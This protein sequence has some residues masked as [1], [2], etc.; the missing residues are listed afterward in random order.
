M[1]ATLS[2]YN[3]PRPRRSG[4][5]LQLKGDMLGLAS[6]VHVEETLCK[7]QGLQPTSLAC[8]FWA[9]GNTMTTSKEPTQVSIASGGRIPPNNWW[10]K[11][12]LCPLDKLCYSRVSIRVTTYRLYLWRKDCRLWPET[13]K[14]LKTVVVPEK[15]ESGNTWYHLRLGCCNIMTVTTPSG[16]VLPLPPASTNEPSPPPSENSDSATPTPTSL[17]ASLPPAESTSQ[18]SLPSSGKSESTTPAPSE[19]FSLSQP[20]PPASLGT[21]IT[22]ISN[23]PSASTPGNTIKPDPVSEKSTQQSHPDPPF[24]TESPDSNP[25]ENEDPK[26]PEKDDTNPPGGDDTKP[27]GD[28]DTKPHRN[29]E[30][31][32]PPANS[33]TPGTLDDS[34]LEID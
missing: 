7:E 12:V 29:T 14:G 32:P 26:P 5:R 28:D 18:P 4:P 31:P 34:T 19:S 20:S 16:T 21:R 8:I 3:H 13:N 30:A 11:Q 10:F 33:D 23:T 17:S 25:P 22:T 24:N 27:P 1:S 2:P 6:S 9:N 15:K